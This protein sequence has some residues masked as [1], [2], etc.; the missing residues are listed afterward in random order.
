MK[1]LGIGEVLEAILRIWGNDSDK[2]R[3]EEQKSCT[4]LVAGLTITW[5]S[6]GEWELRIPG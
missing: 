4:S 1:L 2:G 3:E 6:R 5:G